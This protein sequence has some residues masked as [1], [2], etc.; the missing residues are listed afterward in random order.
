MK[1]ERATPQLRLLL[2]RHARITITV[3]DRPGQVGE[4]IDITR[5]AETL[6][7]LGITLPRS[8][9][10]P[11]ETN[12]IVNVDL[13]EG[14]RA[15]WVDGGGDIS[16]HEVGWAIAAAFE[17]VDSDELVRMIRTAVRQDAVG[18][19]VQFLA[20]AG[21]TKAETTR[22]LNR[23]RA[24]L[25]NRSPREVIETEEDLGVVQTAARL[26]AERVVARLSNDA[27]EHL[28]RRRRTD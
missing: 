18:Q 9:C 8:T 27:L 2:G 17:Q 22:L 11:K 25:G 13:G 28:V 14:G 19:L 4:E 16:G 21:L 26:A 23:R 10:P 20:D 6:T 3:F 1:N 12:A 5:A 15:L 7:A 24:Q